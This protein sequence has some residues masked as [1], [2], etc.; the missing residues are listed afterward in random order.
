MYLNDFEWWDKA[1]F[2]RALGFAAL[3]VLVAWVFETALNKE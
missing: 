2:Y 3:G 1:V